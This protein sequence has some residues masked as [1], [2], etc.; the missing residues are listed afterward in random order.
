MSMDHAVVGAHSA[1]AGPAHLNH[2]PATEA[3]LR[4]VQDFTQL[5]EKSKQLFNGIRFASFISNICC[6]YTNRGYLEILH[7]YII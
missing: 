2:P 4:I 6:E 7:G 3:E 1:I 5:L